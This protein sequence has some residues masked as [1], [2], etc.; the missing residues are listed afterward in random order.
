M[1]ARNYKEFL[2]T[3]LEI[4]EQITLSCQEDNP[5]KKGCLVIQDESYR[6]GHRASV[7]V[8]R[9]E[10]KY[11]NRYFKRLAYLRISEH[12]FNFLLDQFPYE[13]IESNFEGGRQSYL[14]MKKRRDMLADTLTQ[15]IG[16]NP[17][18]TSRFIQFCQNLKELRNLGTFL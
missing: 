17:N 2:E 16:S 7:Q 10:S 14:A 12:I 1:E 4:L 18:A 6:D 8:H 5:N 3:Y 11:M 9:T 15:L 13:L